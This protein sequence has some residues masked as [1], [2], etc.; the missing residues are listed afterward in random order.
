MTI[1]TAQRDELDAIRALLAAAKLPTQDLDTAHIRW[2]VDAHD[3]ALAGVG[4]VETFGDAGLLRSVCVT[5]ARRGSGTGKA[6][7]DA[8]ERWSRAQGMRELVLLTET[9][10]TF[11]ARRG[12]VRV[13]RDAVSAQVQA[14]AQFRAL[15]P[16]SAVCM[17][18][19]LAPIK[20]VLFVCVEN[21][22]RSQMAE[23]FAHLIGG[24]AV[25]ACSAGSRPSGRINPRA[26][27]FMRELGYDL[28]QQHSKALA[29]IDGEFDAVVTMGCGDSCPWIP[30]RLRIDW[31]LP[32]PKDLP[33][34]A[35]RTVRDE[36][37]Q[38]VR[39]LLAQ[40]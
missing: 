18:K 30:A 8:I 20:R 21:S 36:I 29:D 17:R 4:G 35:Y 13:A 16:A 11:F 12:Y 37:A 39:Q 25:F 26:V 6:L 33:D 23:A 40:L 14:S 34:D 7:V 32:D 10:E 1:R 15:C 28:T 38:R 24:D 19:T 2:F 5:E 9:A 31:D 3:G 22:N 27:Q